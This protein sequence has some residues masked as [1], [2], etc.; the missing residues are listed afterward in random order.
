MN[1]SPKSKVPAILR[2]ASGNFIEMFDFFLYGFYAR[3]IA[4]AF[5][6]SDNHYAS[7]LL[8][9]AVFGAGFLMRPI[10]AVVLGAYIDR[11]GR[12][13]GLTLTLALMAL[14][15]F[16]VAFMPGYASVGLAAPIVVFLGRL[17]QGLSAGV[18]L[19]GVSVYLF[20]IAPAHRKGF[21]VGWQSS[22][23]Q[24]ATMAAAGIGYLLNTLVAPAEIHAWAWR[25]PFFVGCLIVPILLVLRNSL[26]ETEAFLARKHHP[27]FSEILLSLAANYRLI[28]HGMLLVVMT[29]VTFYLVAVYTPTFGRT[30][31]KL[32]ASD[33]LATTFV[34]GLLSFFCV[35]AMGAVSDRV[36]RRPVLYGATI[37]GVLT[38]YPA[39]SW[40][41]ANPDFRHLLV[42]ELWLAFLYGAYNGAAMVTLTEIMPA[43]VRTVGF[44]FAFSLAVAIFGGFTPLVSTW[45]IHATGDKAAPG[46]WMTMASMCGVVATAMLRTE[47]PAPGSLA[48]RRRMRSAFRP[49][50]VPLAD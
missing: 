6:P 45:L 43:H 20:E 19:G 27:R 47:A 29:T 31:L 35:P 21:Y 38:A 7:L 46:I 23:L 41:V 10:G 37:L 1:S 30:V 25:V 49:A 8:T 28:I 9:F 15:T 50:G 44:A 24:V 36:G 4:A 17:L 12:R 3:Y 11:V 14:G 40:L 13:K 33:S 18:E 48:S 42:V 16:T 26:E 34:V 2:V 32:S 39:L 5:F 22:S